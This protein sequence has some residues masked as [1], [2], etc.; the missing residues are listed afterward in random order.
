[1]QVASGTK[2][3]KRKTGWAEVKEKICT[4]PKSPVATI[5]EGK[6]VHKWTWEKGSG[7]LKGNREKGVHGEHDVTG[8]GV[9]FSE[10]SQGS[11][12]GRKGTLGIKAVAHVR[13]GNEKGFAGGGEGSRVG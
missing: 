1:M 13:V 12:G 8:K 2:R 3:E 5:K 10:S 11:R 9:G 6:G 4:V 7:R